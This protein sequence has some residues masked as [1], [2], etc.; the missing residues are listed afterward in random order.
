VKDNRTFLLYEYA[1]SL[2]SSKT[3]SSIVLPANNNV[4]VF[5]VT[6]KP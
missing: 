3:V 6:M 1:F 5:A 2:D 4:K